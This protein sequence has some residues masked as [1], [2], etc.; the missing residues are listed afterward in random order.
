[1]ADY[2]EELALADDVPA[3]IARLDLIL[4]GNMLRQDSK[5][6]IAQ[7]LAEIPINVDTE[8][9]DRIF[10]V[11]IAISMVMSSPGYLVQR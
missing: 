6:R 9:T 8:A 5:D 2:T 1:M 7:L 3:L 11:T 10:R 4:T